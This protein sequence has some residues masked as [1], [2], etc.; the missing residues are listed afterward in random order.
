MKGIR[1]T[2]TVFD[3][4]DRERVRFV[5]F[6]LFSFIWTRCDCLLAETVLG[7]WCFTRE[8]LLPSLFS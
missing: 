8:I 5:R 4:P 7:G 2:T 3:R 6:I 1:N